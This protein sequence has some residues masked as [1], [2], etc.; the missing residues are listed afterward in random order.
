[1]TDLRGQ[2]PLVTGAS[3]GVGR[4]VVVGLAQA[5]ATVF[6]TG[7]T[8]KQTEFG[9]GINCIACDHKDDQSPRSTES[10]T[11][12]AVGLGHRR[13]RTYGPE[14]PART[15]ADWLDRNP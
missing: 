15:S 12:M 9:T 4:G 10:P 14:H 3:R 7:R 11:L 13:S 6:A 1:M 8:I 2:G 5:G